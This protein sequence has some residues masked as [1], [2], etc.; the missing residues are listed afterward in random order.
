MTKQ[1]LINQ[2]Q[3]YTPHNT[4]ELKHRESILKFLSEQDNNFCRSNLSGHIT[5]SGFLLNKNR[6]QI[7][8]THH[9]KLNKWLQFGGHA[10]GSSDILSV[11]IREAQEES[12]IEN[13][14]PINTSI[15]DV[16][17]HIIPSNATKGEP[18]HFHYDVRYLLW[19]SENNFKISEESLYLKWI[20]V[21][22][23]LDF[24]KEKSFIR[25]MEK[26]N[27]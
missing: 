7:L 24:V 21:N 17:V 23:I 4:T 13:I 25:V 10:D 19:T 8:L 26:F 15:F 5:G 12:G 20:D 22:K 3:N 9:R 2:L 18:E 16:D 1:I 14:L 27:K 11:A 6:D